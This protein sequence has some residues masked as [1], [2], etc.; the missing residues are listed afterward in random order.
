MNTLSCTC[1]PGGAAMS[2]IVCAIR[3]GPDSQP[4]IAR[5][6]AL[7]Q[8]TNLPLNFLYIVNLDFLTHTTG[9]RIQTI[10]EEMHQMGEFILLTAQAT[11]AQHGVEAEGF[12]RHGDVREEIIGLCREVAADYLVLGQ[13]KTEQGECIFSGDELAQFIQHTE[14]HIGASVRLSDRKNS[15]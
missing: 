8:E 14:K 15:T 7:A 9:S 13:P 10:T 4:T 12:V 2:G 3:G 5:A 11:A 1:D 6:I